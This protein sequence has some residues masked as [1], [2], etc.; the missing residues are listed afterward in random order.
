MTGE[1]SRDNYEPMASME[2]PHEFR[3]GMKVR[4]FNWALDR[5]IRAKGWKRKE[6]AAHCGIALVTLITW[7]SFRA[8]PSKKKR[9][10]ASD[11]LGVSEEILFPEE[12]K[13]IRV[14]RQPT[15]LSFSREEAM[16]LG[17][18]SEENDPEQRAFQVSL[19]E[20]LQAAMQNMKERERFVLKM[21]FGLEGEDSHTLEDIAT[22]LGVTRER[23][24][25]MEKKAMR[26]V[27][28][29]RHALQLHTYLEE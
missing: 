23:I 28:S 20:A 7:L 3:V 17:L 4:V 1:L 24:R 16:E 14:K 19:Q 12:I 6:A 29:Q 18:C 9:V 26:I 27:W 13:D 15:A 5:A 2:L 10:V 22:L 8:Y 21:R 25:Q 11:V